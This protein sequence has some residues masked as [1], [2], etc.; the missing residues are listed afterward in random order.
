MGDGMTA[1]QSLRTVDT[2]ALGHVASVQRP[3]AE[4]SRVAAARAKAARRAKAAIRAK[5]L[6]RKRFLWPVRGP[7]TSRFGRRVSPITGAREF[8]H[9]TDLACHWGQ[10]LRSPKA[11]RV[12]LARYD[13]VYGRSVKIRHTGGWVSFTTHMSRL[14]VRKGARVRQGERIG[15]CGRSGWATGS[16]THFELRNP[17]GRVVDPVRHVWPRKPP[18]FRARR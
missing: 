10:I 12:I 16:H 6:M 3:G 18:R 17:T 2:T 13:W 8:H 15:R 11:G 9:G 5:R 7:V 4:A 14:R 1:K